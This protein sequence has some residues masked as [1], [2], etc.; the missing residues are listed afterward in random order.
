MTLMLSDST[1]PALPIIYNVHAFSAAFTRRLCLV[2]R[3]VDHVAACTTGRAHS[4]LAARSEAGLA[5]PRLEKLSGRRV[6][7]GASADRLLTALWASPSAKAQHTGP[8]PLQPGGVGRS[9]RV[10]SQCRG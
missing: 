4:S 6:R 8:Q 1:R 2:C 5:P 3:Q 10:S 7:D 9:R